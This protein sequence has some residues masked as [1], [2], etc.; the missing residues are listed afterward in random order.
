M[1]EEAFWTS[2]PDMSDAELTERV[3]LGRH[4]FLVQVSPVRHFDDY[5]DEVEVIHVW[6]LREDGR[7]LALRDLNPSI[8]REAAYNQ[9]GFLCDQLTAAASLAYGLR[10]NP[11]GAVNPMLGCWGPR[12]DLISGEPDDASTAL[13]VGVA[14]DTRDAVRA[15]RPELTALALR[16]AVVA[17]L[18]YWVREAAPHR[19][20]NPRD[21]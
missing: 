1:S 6:A 19:I 14:V 7:P 13:V 18:R 2:L 15:E 9:W 11:D 12:P 3:D 16:S 4:S 5:D 21:N 10:D 8:S 17:A 20:P